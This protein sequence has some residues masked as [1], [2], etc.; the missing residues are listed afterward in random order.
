MRRFLSAVSFLTIIP[1]GPG[2]AFDARLPARSS[3]FFSIVGALFGLALAALSSGLLHF[4]SPLASAALT[5][6]AWTVLSGALHLDGL[7]DTADGLGGGRDKAQRLL[8]M[9][10]SRIGTFGAAAVCIVLLLKTALIVE[11]CGGG[12]S[13]I[14]LP[15]G[16]LPSA[17]VLAPVMGRTVM[18][19]AVFAF[20]AARKTGLGS[21]FKADC[22]VVDAVICAGVALV[23]AVL[24]RALWGLLSALAVGALGMAA[25]ALL[26]RGLGGL[27]GDSYG[28]LCEGCELS[29][30]LALAILPAG[31][32]LG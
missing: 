13:S 3:A 26:S 28:A 4:L 10:D 31:G 24:F 6:T 15:F 22:R 1:A 16:K 19:L 5:V 30:L 11:L 23:L 32:L 14:V 8:I 17:L 9:K 2:G 25:A 7:A 12:S 20:P 18:A 21:S 29:G 27:T